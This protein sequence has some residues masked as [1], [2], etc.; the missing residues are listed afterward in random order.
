MHVSGQTLEQRKINFI[1]L[2]FITII[3]AVLIVCINNC[4]LLSC[5]IVRC[6]HEFPLQSFS[7][8]LVLVGQPLRPALRLLAHLVQANLNIHFDLHLLQNKGG[9]Q[10]FRQNAKLTHLSQNLKHYGSYY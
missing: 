7:D 6:I 3:V 1:P 4:V 8:G 2:V 5:S 10:I 9:E